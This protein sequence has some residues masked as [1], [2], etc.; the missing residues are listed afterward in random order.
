[1]ISIPV[2]KDLTH[3]ALQ[4][5]LDGVTY[6]LRVRWN[7]RASAWFMDILTEDADDVIAAG[8]RIVVGYPLNLYRADRKPPGLLF[9]QDTSGRGVDPG[10]GELGERVQLFY[11][12]TAEMAELGVQR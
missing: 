10:L 1:M 5:S 8:L 9:A 11:L 12:S 4:V 7:A 2:R 6:T 3:F